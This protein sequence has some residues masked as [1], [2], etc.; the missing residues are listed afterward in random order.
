MISLVIHGWFNPVKTCKTKTDGLFNSSTRGLKS[1][2]LKMSSVKGHK[3]VQE[4]KT[5]EPM[6]S[7]THK[8]KIRH[9]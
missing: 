2:N 5:Q 9:Y 8:L 3:K 1:E 4:A 6:N 7:Q